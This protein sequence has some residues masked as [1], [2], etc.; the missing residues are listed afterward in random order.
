MPLAAG[1]AALVAGTLFGWDSRLVDALVSP[2]AL[3]RAG[4]VAVA[5]LIG[6]RLLARAVGG[7][8]R[9]GEPAT[10]A[11]W[12]AWSVR[13]VS[14][15]W[16]WPRCPRRPAGS[17]EA[18][19]RS[20]S[21]WSSPASTSSRPRSCCWW[22]G[23]DRVRAADP[24]AG[25]R[26]RPRGGRRSG[27]IPGG[28][29]RPPW[30]EAAARCR[31]TPAPTS[32]PRRRH[33]IGAPSRTTRPARMTTTR[34]NDSA[35]KRMSWLIAMTVRPE[36]I[37]SATTAGSGRLR[38]RPVRSSAHR[39]PR[40]ASASPGPRRATAASGGSSPDRTGSSRSRPARPT[41]SSAAVAAIA[42]SFGG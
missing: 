21:P 39:A 4:L 25:W 36:A 29:D 35:T 32:G 42:A 20:S 15:S 6:A 2:P 41:A 19:C 30:P 7:L 26:G 5:V 13:C 8:S 11:T 12:R 31:S 17:W 33:S 37:R 22:S 34:P 18:R 14:S 38:E 28:A 1:V 24:S 27:W 9:A 10:F 40:P 16:R 3:V 23:P